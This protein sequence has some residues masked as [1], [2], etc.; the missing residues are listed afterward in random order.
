MRISLG[1]NLQQKQTQVLAPRMIQSMEILQMPL[2]ALEERIEQELIDNPVLERR[3]D[4]PDAASETEPE[5]DTS[6]QVEDREKELVIDE[7]DNR[8]DFDRLM[9]LDREVPEYFDA[10]RPSSNRI[11]EMGDRQHD[12]LANVEDRHETLQDYLLEQLADYELEEPVRRMCERIIS[13]LNAEDGGYFRASLRDLLP[14]DASEEDYELAEE[15]LAIVQ[16]LEP[17]GIAA[18]DLKECLLLQLRPDMKHFDLVRKL[19][20]DHL[21]DLQHNR[22]PQIEKATGATIDEIQQAWEEL[23]HLDPKPA[24]RFA[25]RVVPVV[26]PDLR[27]VQDDDGNYVV[28]MEEG[29]GRGLYIS[30][31]YR[32]RLAN[33]QATPEEKE[34]I[35]RKV[36]AA[37]WL[38]ESIEQR[39]STLKKVAQAIVDHQK[40]F[41]DDG[42]EHMEPLKMQQIAD[43]VGVHVTTV[44][45]AVDDKWI[46]TP[47]GIFPLRRFFVH[48]TT[49]DDGEEVAWD[50]IRIALQ[51]LIDEEDKSNPLS[52]DEIVKRLKSQGFKVARRTVTKYRQKMNI[53]SSRQRRDWSK[54]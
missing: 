11:Q 13:T 36:M 53:P 27:V 9:E 44:S 51:K 31:Y 30:N 43:K 10:D 26:T 4:D 2:A 7:K 17:E 8:D 6:N 20:T 46:E 18:R 35:K 29:P 47:R 23:R 25:H 3:D 40:K 38:I 52:D 19:I 28:E 12:L 48:G 42:P 22:L 16:S 14:P 50:S 54:R 15:A 39:K 34:F 1:Q 37:Q 24:S 49:T 33:G 41:L 32:K 45:R 5:A 21:D